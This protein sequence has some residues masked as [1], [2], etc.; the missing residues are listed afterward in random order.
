MTLQ[1]VVTGGA[2]GIGLAIVERLKQANYHVSVL[3]LVSGKD[4]IECDVSDCKSV[5][6]IA[7][8]I[9]PVDVLVNNA[10]IWKF[11]ALEETSIE[12][13][14]K[15]LDVNLKGAFNTMKHFGSGM[16]TMG[17]GSIINIVSIAGKHANASVGSYGPSK[18]ALISLTE[19]AALEWGPR[20][21]RCNGVGPGLV[22][23]PG[24]QS[25]YEDVSVRELRAKSIP[26][27]R[28]AQPSDIAEA[29]HYLATDQS[30]YINGQILYVDG[31]LSKA[32]MT[33]LPRPESLDS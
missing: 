21:V 1:A 19:Q 10:A 24:T 2:R 30:A 25:V 9:G 5:G 31:G 28:L 16:L 27:Q 14:S 23:T 17:Q 13:F 32:L 4:I 12:D 26:L 8:E 7:A 33:L 3:D 20:G 6:A 18:A 29:V 11:G 22:P 15:V